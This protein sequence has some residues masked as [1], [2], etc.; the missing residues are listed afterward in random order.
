MCGV[1][2]LPVNRTPDTRRRAVFCVGDSSSVGLEVGGECPLKESAGNT[3]DT[4]F[5][6]LVDRPSDERE[7]KRLWRRRGNRLG[8]DRVVGM[9]QFEQN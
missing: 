3:R 6:C 7:M 2:K 1:E 9:S 5:W 4:T 8:G